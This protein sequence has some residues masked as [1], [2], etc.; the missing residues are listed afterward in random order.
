MKSNTVGPVIAFLARLLNVTIEAPASGFLDLN[1]GA[2]RAQV[3]EAF[4][5]AGQGWH[6]L[7]PKVV[8]GYSEMDAELDPCS[9]S[10]IE[11]I[12]IPGAGVSISY[13]IELYKTGGI[14]NL[15]LVDDTYDMD[16]F[17]PHSPIDTPSN[18]D[19]EVWLT[20]DGRVTLDLSY[21]EEMTTEQQARLLA[22]L[23]RLDV[24]FAWEQVPLADL[25][26]ESLMEY[27]HQEN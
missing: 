26:A 22:I 6:E 17:N 16:E 21:H 23:S 4:K 3:R 9:L 1:H 11:W 7:A 18:L 13:E 15:K 5:N 8:L 14:G 12:K 25:T 24:T 19:F 27:I 10:S 2:V 20:G